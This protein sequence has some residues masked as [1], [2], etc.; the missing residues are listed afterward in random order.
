VIAPIF[1]NCDRC[2]K[3]NQSTCTVGGKAQAAV[4]IDVTPAEEGMSTV[5]RAAL[6]VIALLLAP[7]AADAGSPTIG[8]GAEGQ[9]QVVKATA[10]LVREIQFL[11]LSLSLDPGPIDG[12]ARQLT[13]R[14]LHLFQQRAGL[15]AVDIVND[16]MVSVVLVERLR[17]EAAQVLLKS[18]APQPAALPAPEPVAARLPKAPSPPPD[19]F[20]SCPYNPA[21]FLIGGKQ[22]TPQTF[23][24]E[25]FNGAT[26]SAVT[27]LR[28]R[29]DEARQIAEKIGGPA[30]GE[31]QR[32]AHVLAYFEC[33]Q[34]IEQS[35]AAKN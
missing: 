10:P 3:S 2:R 4:A 32:Q 15:P 1:S 12:N 18:A 8:A 29:L 11:L 19:R 33:R 7:A 27:N 9:E 21:D 30:L 13:N 22:F 24:D 17:K 23:L 26:A 34:Q 5:V 14:A 20:A 35:S 25:G 31:V 16:G 28:H 6:C